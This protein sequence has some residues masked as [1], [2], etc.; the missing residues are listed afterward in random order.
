MVFLHLTCFSEVKRRTKKWSTKKWVGGQPNDGWKTVSGAFGTAG[1]AGD[2]ALL[3]LFFLRKKE[4]WL[5]NTTDRRLTGD[6]FTIFIV[7]FFEYSYEQI[8]DICL[9]K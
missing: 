3:L 8:F 9:D 6:D 5:L 7:A 2:D 1:P 4:R